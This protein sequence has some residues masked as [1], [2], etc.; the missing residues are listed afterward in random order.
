[1][2]TVKIRDIRVIN[3]NPAGANLTVIKVETTEPGLYGVTMPLKRP[4]AAVCISSGVTGLLAGI[5]GVSASSFASPSLLAL[6]IFVN[7]QRANNLVMAVICAAVS[8]VLSFLVTWFMGFQDPA[9]DESGAPAESKPEIQEPGQ[10][11]G[12]Q[13]IGAPVAGKTL[14]LEQVNDETFS[15][16]VLG[17]GV[18]IVP[19]EGKVYAPFDGKVE[20]IPD[21]HHALGLLSSSG[22]ELLVHVGLETVRLNGKHFQAHVQE[23]QAIH[24]GDL[25]LEFDKDAIA[26]EGF[27][28][29]TPVIV[30]NADDYQQVIPDVNKTV[31][32]QQPV[33]QIL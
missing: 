7:A 28:L 15:T 19:S 3:T 29:V 9:T 26:A 20:T 33:L 14:P 22:V 2:S 32:A 4:L 5:L 31:K 27:D 12:A 30:T 10:T 17:M 24:Q 23:G 8:I 11:G 6:P 18:A 25:L 13:A 21:S 16:G 1:M